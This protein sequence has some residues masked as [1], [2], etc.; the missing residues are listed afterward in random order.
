MIETQTQTMQDVKHIII[1]TGE[2]SGDVLGASL[3]PYIKAVFPNAKFSGIGAE[4]IKAVEPEFT[5]LFEM[6]DLSVM[7]VAEVLPA[8]PRILK[9]LKETKDYIIDQQPDLVITI[10]APDFNHRVTRAVKP[11]CPKTKFVHYVAPSVWAWRPKRAKR[12]AKIYDGLLC[13][14]PFEPAYFEQE[15]LTSLFV[16]HPAIE[17]VGAPLSD[18]ERRSQRM[19][20]FEQGDESINIVSVLFG[21]RTGE[22]KRHSDIII[23]AMAQIKDQTSN[24]KFFIPVFERFKQQIE[25]QLKSAGFDENDFYFVTTDQRYDLFKISDYA[26]A[27]SGTVGL[28]LAIAKT[29]HCICYRFGWFTGLIAKML[30]KTPYA[31]I[32]NIVLKE[33]FIPEFL[34]DN[35]RSDL[36]ASDALKALH[37]DRRSQL[38]FRSK[39]ASLSTTLKNENLTHKL[40]RFLAKL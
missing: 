38:E 25:I 26:I 30:I 20:Y 28:E 27:V 10:D 37:Q 2:A 23:E 4:E 9:R 40:F 3:I 12:I 14:L 21:S 17:R 24:T 19:K 16:G 11:H 34:Q 7:G 33:P 6:A 36:I 18:D 32:A 29:P 1:L 8:L 15:G 31:H 5:S 35:C 13:L 22:I 39:V